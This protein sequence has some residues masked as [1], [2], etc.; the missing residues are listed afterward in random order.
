[1]TQKEMKLT[2]YEYL[3]Y[4]KPDWDT[5]ETV[6]QVSISPADLAIFDETQGGF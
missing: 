1:M 3:K 6:L 4:N 5:Q 2:F